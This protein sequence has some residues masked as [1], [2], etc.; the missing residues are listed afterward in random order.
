MRAGLHAFGTDFGNG[1]RDRLYFQRDHELDR[2]QRE[3]QKVPAT[4]HVVVDDTGVRAAACDRAFSFVYDTLAQEHNVVVDRSGPRAAQWARVAHL[5]QEDLAVLHRGVDDVGD[6]IVLNVC[7]PSGWR[8]E[9][10]KEATFQGIH[11]PVP[12]FTDKK[13]VA[14]SMVRAMVDRGPYVRF[15]WTC[16]ADDDLDHHPEEGRRA[17]WGNATHGWLRVERQTTV[18]FADAGAA[19]FLIRTYLYPF[20]S[21]STEEKQTLT[22]ALTVMSD[23][24]ATYKGL[25]AGKARILELLGE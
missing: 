11:V 16:S 22:T 5:V 8:P 15:V 10:L 1:D 13:A 12:A 24:I 20:A 4:R 14:Q 3:K 7:F 18:P 25:L 23:E 9:R 6:T 21:L 2:Y 19:L 17:P